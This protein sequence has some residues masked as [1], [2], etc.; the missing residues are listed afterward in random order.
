MSTLPNSARDTVFVSSNTSYIL[1]NFHLN[2]FWIKKCFLNLIIN[3]LICT[4]YWPWR[5]LIYGL[6]HL[7]IL[8]FSGKLMQIWG[9]TDIMYIDIQDWYRLFTLKSV[10]GYRLSCLLG[11]GFPCWETAHQW[12]RKSINSRQRRDCR[13][14]SASLLTRLK[15]WHVCLT[16]SFETKHP[17]LRLKTLCQEVMQ[18]CFFIHQTRWAINE[19]HP[20]VLECRVHHVA[21]DVWF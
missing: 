11:W 17:W 4:A 21:C 16:V 7:K 8:Q 1:I 6:V 9:F 15:C 5:N 14:L 12:V 10:N 20:A 3:Y 18:V 19:I 2:F 13:I